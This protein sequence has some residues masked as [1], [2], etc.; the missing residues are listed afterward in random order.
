[1]SSLNMGLLARA[2]SSEV[3]AMIF[4][5]MRYGIDSGEGL[6][7]RALEMAADIIGI[8]GELY[9][10]GECLDLLGL[11]VDIWRSIEL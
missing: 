11:L 9:T 3:R 1:M 4:E 5:V 8:D 2:T 7:G 6:D 10:D